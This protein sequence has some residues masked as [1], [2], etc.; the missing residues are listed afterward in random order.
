MSPGRVPRKSWWGHNWI[1]VALVLLFVWTTIGFYKV[2]QEKSNRINA[3][4]NFSVELRNGLVASCEKN[5]NPLRTAV[6]GMLEEEIKQTNPKLLREFFPQIPPEMLE[7]IVNKQRARKE[8]V[9]K[10]IAP[11][12][13]EALYPKIAN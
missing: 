9:I 3:V 5:G 6:Q 2:E 12:N 8:E 7:R 13:C 11:I 10:E 1:K 4:Q